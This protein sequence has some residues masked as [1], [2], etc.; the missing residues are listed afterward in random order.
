MDGDGPRWWKNRDLRQLNNDELIFTICEKEL[1]TR[2]AT[3][4]R[5]IERLGAVLTTY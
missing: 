4:A 1:V 3:K 5:L 2:N